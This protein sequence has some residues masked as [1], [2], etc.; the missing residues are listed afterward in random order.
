MNL[1]VTNTRA[2]QAYSIIRALRPHTKKIVATMYGKNFLTAWLTSHAAHSRLVD[3]YYHVPSFAGDWKRGKI[4]EENTPK[5]QAYIE[6]VSRICK[7]E[8]IDTIF[9]SWDAQIYT[10]SKNKKRFEKLGVRI[11]IP[12][13]KT[14]VIVLDKYRALKLAEEAGFACPT[15]YV[16]RNLKDV[17]LIAEEIEFPV[18][19]KPRFVSWGIE[20]ASDSSELLA[21]TANFIEGYGM[22]IIQEFIPGGLR[23]ELHFIM[24]KRGELKLA[25]HRSIERS[26]RLD[27]YAHIST[28]NE[29][30]NFQPF[31]AHA[32]AFLQN[33]HRL[34][35]WGS[36]IVETAVD[37]RD[38]KSKFMELIPRFRRQLW[39]SIE[40]G[41]NEPRICISIARGEPVETV[42][43]YPAGTLF[44]SP[45]EDVLILL[46]QILD[47]LVHR[48]RRMV[49]QTAQ[50]P[51]SLPLS[52]NQLT[53]SFARTY[54]GRKRKIVDPYFRYF[55]RDP[56][57][58]LLWWLQLSSW[59]FGLARRLGR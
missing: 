36:G 12:D 8:Q 18:T 27:S 35:W 39:N 22:S 54:F 47:L 10:F 49:G 42:K 16:P 46:F 41:I 52:L 31:Q 24:D 59:V 58:S 25:F 38:G 32:I 40:L 56:L 28:V 19:V 51:W 7:T 29:L 37:P 30:T 34:G 2:A 15:T 53:R 33:L 17:R 50:D 3:K 55:F 45:I 44:L 6:E 20:I 1:L 43:S 48:V 11:P 4:T 9:P 57:V 14:C 23:Q 5:E 13:Y 21:K 26:L